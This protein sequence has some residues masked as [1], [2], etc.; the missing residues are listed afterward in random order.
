MRILQLLHLNYSVLKVMLHVSARL[1]KI[2]MLPLLTILFICFNQNFVASTVIPMRVPLIVLTQARS[3]ASTF[4]KKWL[5]DEKLYESYNNEHE[6]KISLCAREAFVT[7]IT[8]TSAARGALLRSILSIIANRNCNWKLFIVFPKFEDRQCYPTDGEARGQCKSL[9]ALTKDPPSILEALPPFI[10]NDPR[11]EFLGVLSSGSE[12]QWAGPKRN[13]AIQYV[14]TSF[15]AFLDDDDLLTPSYVDILFSSIQMHTDAT[16]FIFRMSTQ[17]Y[18]EHGIHILPPPFELDFSKG[19]VGISFALR[20]NLFAPEGIHA[21]R[22][23]PIE[24]FYLLDDLRS[25]GEK[26]I[27]SPNLTYLVR[28]FV[29]PVQTRFCQ[30]E[31][32]VIHLNDQPVCTNPPSAIMKRDFKTKRLRRGLRRNPTK[33]ALGPVDVFFPESKSAFFSNNV[34]GLV[35]SLQELVKKGCVNSI[36]RK[37]PELEI[38]FSPTASRQTKSK[39]LIQFHIEQILDTSVRG[40]AGELFNQNYVAKLKSA[41]QVWSYAPSHYRFLSL[42]LNLTNVFLIPLWHAVLMNESTELCNKPESCKPAKIFIFS[43]IRYPAFDACYIY[44]CLACNIDES[45]AFPPVCPAPRVLFFG[46]IQGSYLNRRLHMCEVM[47]TDLDSQFMCAEGLFGAQLQAVLRTV[48]I[49]V[50][51]H[52]YE[53]SVLEVHRI[54]PLLASGKIIVSTRS[55]DKQLDAVYEGVIFFV[56][57]VAHMVLKVRELLQQSRADLAQLATRNRDFLKSKKENIEPLCAAFLSLYKYR[58]KRHA[59]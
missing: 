25:C 32:S 1:E 34:K 18:R 30:A 21:F 42:Q 15:V 48:E 13:S 23:G 12:S 28:G 40:T 36:D 57:T 43:L 11:I 29:P 33:R 44:P 51:E 58:L 24:D 39:L 5:A 45:T 41:S 4:V 56:D 2:L 54:N 14:N 50:I 59:A 7:F 38:H 6:K 46:A 27:L 47:A 26:M 3:Y 17:Y 8:P 31:E 55:F 35:S 9:P 19:F 52:Y 20:R 22:D 49:I 16:A 53:H 37:R 10:K